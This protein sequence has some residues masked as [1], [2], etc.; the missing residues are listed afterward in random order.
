MLFCLFADTSQDPEGEF[1]LVS[2]QTFGWT[3]L[4]VPEVRD[5]G[6]CSLGLGTNSSLVD[7][8]CGSLF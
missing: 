1:C 6:S 8:G 7:P 3:L 5:R 4:A 2:V